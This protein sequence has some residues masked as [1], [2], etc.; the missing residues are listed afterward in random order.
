MRNFS[1]LFKMFKGLHSAIFSFLLILQIL[2]KKLPNVTGV[3]Q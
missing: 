1:A 2:A 3:L